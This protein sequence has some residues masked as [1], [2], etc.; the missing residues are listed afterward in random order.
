MRQ[1]TQW[2]GKPRRIP[3]CWAAPGPVPT[4]LLSSPLL[5]IPMGKVRW[6]W[7][8]KSCRISPTPALVIHFSR[9]APQPRAIKLSQTL[10]TVFT[11]DAPHLL[12][13]TDSAASQHFLLC[14]PAGTGA[15]HGSQTFPAELPPP[16]PLHIPPTA[17]FPTSPSVQ[18]PTHQQQPSA[19]LHPCPSAFSHLKLCKGGQ[20]KQ[21]WSNEA[22]L[23]FQFYHYAVTQVPATKN[24]PKNPTT[25]TTRE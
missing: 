11:L 21:F 4:D 25:T 13:G 2:D 8:V 19:V 5:Q 9:L 3:C 1:D 24:K 15:Q 12:R 6:P 10:V 7:Q 22:L 18:T 17:C 20:K 16:P 14:C 23:I